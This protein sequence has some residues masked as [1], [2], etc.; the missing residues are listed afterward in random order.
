MLKTPG[1]GTMLALIRSRLEPKIAPIFFHSGFRHMQALVKREAAP[2][3]WL[4]VDRRDVSFR[5]D[6][7]GERR[8]DVAN[9]GGTRSCP[10]SG[11]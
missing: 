5:T 1:N 4:E 8:S 10:R 3:L 9:A 2:G 11:F 7:L 6:Q